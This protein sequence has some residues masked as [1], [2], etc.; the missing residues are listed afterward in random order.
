MV[1]F[2]TIHEVAVFCSLYGFI[3]IIHISN[4]HTDLLDQYDL[5]CELII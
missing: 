3:Y 2:D 4:F 1:I 5:S